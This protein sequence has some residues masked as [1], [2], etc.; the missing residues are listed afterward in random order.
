MTNKHLLYSK[1]WIVDVTEDLQV[2]L[3]FPG[4]E[5]VIA[6]ILIPSRKGE[7]RYSRQ[8]DRHWQLLDGNFG[9]ITIPIHLQK[10]KVDLEVIYAQFLVA[11]ILYE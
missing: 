9:Q 3:V 7:Q 8:P 10:F 6:S 11:L 4:P 5:R 1:P 2:K